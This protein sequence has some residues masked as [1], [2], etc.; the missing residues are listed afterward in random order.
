MH[1]IYGLSRKRQPCVI[2]MRY[3]ALI[4]GAVSEET[5]LCH[6]DEVRSF[7]LGAVSKE[8]AA[9]TIRFIYATFFT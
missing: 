3:G 7:E 2:L 9:L 4:L 5:A 6:L 1:L 8:T